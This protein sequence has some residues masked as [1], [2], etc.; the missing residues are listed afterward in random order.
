MVYIIYIL[1]SRPVFLQKVRPFRN[2]PARQHVEIWEKA[3]GREGQQRFRHERTA[4]IGQKRLVKRR[5]AD[6]AH[7]V[8][9]EVFDF[10]KQRRHGGKHLR[11]LDA[12]VWVA[13]QNQIP[14]AWERA[15]MRKGFERFSPHNDGFSLRQRAKTAQISGSRRSG[16]DSH[17][18]SPHLM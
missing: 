5:A 15:R 9:R 13:R 17:R 8:R 3:V 11:A 2:A 10:R 4:A 7:L 14:P 18:T 6:Q 12:I 1:E 16:R